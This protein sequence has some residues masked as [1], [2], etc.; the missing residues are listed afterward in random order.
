MGLFTTKSRTDD[1]TDPAKLLVTEHEKVERLFAEIE[2]A[3]SD[4]SRRS[5]VGQLDAE[6]SAHMLAE[7][8]LLYP[9]IRNEVPDGDTLMDRAEREHAEAADALAKLVVADPGT[10]EFPKALATLQKLV[11]AHVKEEEKRVFPALED[12]LDPVRLGDIRSELEDAKFTPTVRPLETAAAPAPR[13]TRKSS[14]PSTTTARRSKT[15]GP[16]PVWVQSHAGDDRWQVKREGASRASRVFDTQRAAEQFGRTLA[17]RE[18]VELVI[19]G[20][21]GTIRQRD[22]YGNDPRSSKG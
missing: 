15:S 4:N 21:D 8:K 7:E 17:K 20:R 13:S 14:K 10:P 9:V 22:S 1:L 6:L 2:E 11:K 12:A 5:L 16:T 3:D 19:A 18:R